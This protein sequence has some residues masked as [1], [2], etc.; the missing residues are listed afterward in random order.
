MGGGRPEGERPGG[1]EGEEQISLGASEP[2]FSS[3]AAWVQFLALSLSRPVAL[4]KSF[5][6]SE[7]HLIPIP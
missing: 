1:R 7:L 2:G 4:G 6:L 5:D 3:A